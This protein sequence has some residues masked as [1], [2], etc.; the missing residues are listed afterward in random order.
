MESQRRYA[1]RKLTVGVA[2]VLIGISFAGTATSGHASAAEL[3][4]ANNTSLTTQINT[5]QSNS[6]VDA[7][8]VKAEQQSI[9]AKSTSNVTTNTNPAST[10][11]ENPN[12]KKDTRNSLPTQNQEVKTNNLNTLKTNESTT[13]APNTVINQNNTQTLNVSQLSKQADNIATL[14]ESKVAQN[15]QVKT[16]KKSDFALYWSADSADKV[17][18]DFSDRHEG[19]ISDIWSGFKG[20][21][22]ID[23][24]D[25][26][27]GNQIF[28]GSVT[29]TN[30]FYTNASQDKVTNPEF[31]II[32]EPNYVPISTKD[33][34]EFG[35]VQA[36]KPVGNRIDLNLFITQDKDIVGDV[37]INVV[38]PKFF[39]FNY[40]TPLKVYKGIS[41]DRPFVETFTLSNGKKYTQT[42]V[43]PNP[44]TAL[45]K[46]TV[47]HSSI[48]AAGGNHRG[49]LFDILPASQ[50]N[51]ST[52]LKTNSIL[53]TS[54]YKKVVQITGENVNLTL[55]KD[56]SYNGF[57]YIP[58]YSVIDADGNITTERVS[59]EQNA[60]YNKYP[61]SI[62]LADN[63]T[64]QQ[65]M[66]QLSSNQMGLS[67]QTSGG[68]LV[69]INLDSN[70]LKFSDKVISDMVDNKSVLANIQDPDNKQKIIDNTVNFYKTR[71]GNTPIQMNFYFPLDV[72]ASANSEFYFKDVTPGTTITEQKSAYIGSAS[73]N[74]DGALAKYVTYE[75]IDDDSSNII[76]GTPITL[77]GK[78]GDVVTP[79]MTVPSNYELVAGQ[80]LPGSYTLK[81]VNPTTE[82]HIK[83]K[84][85]P[86]SETHTINETIHYIY[87]DGSIA[88][89]DH[90]A[91]PV[92]VIRTGDKDL[93]T[94]NVKW[95]SW[96]TET[97][98]EIVT[99]A[100]NGYTADQAKI[101]AYTVNGDAKDIV[102]TVTY[103]A[104]NQKITINYIDDTTKA[105]VGTDSLVGKSNTDS[106]YNTKAHISNFEKIGYDLVSDDTN[107]QNIKYDSD[108]TKDQNYSIHLK[109]HISTVT[110]NKMLKASFDRTIIENLPDGKNKEIKQHY[111]I[112][113]TG[114][115][116]QVTKKYTFTPWTTAQVHEDKIDVVD[117]YTAQV[118]NSSP[119]GF[120]SISNEILAAKGEN[121]TGDNNSL[122]GKDVVETAV[123]VYTPNDQKAKITYF[124]DSTGKILE[125]QNLLGKTNTDSGY[126]TKDRID[127]YK[128]KGYELVSDNTDGQTIK[129]DA[130]DKVD[131]SYEVHFKHHISDVTDSK[132][133]KAFFDRTVTTHTP[134]GKDKVAKQHYV[135]LRTGTQ[136]QVTKEYKFT[137]WSKVQVREDKGDILDG[138][139][140][141]VKNSNIKDIA[142]VINGVPT[143]KA[144]SF[145]GDNKALN[146]K[147]IVENVEFIYTP[148]DQKASVTYID[149]TTNE[150]LLDVINLIGK[151]NTESNYSTK[152]QIEAYQKDGYDLVSDNTNGKNIVFD[153]KDKVDQHFEVHV[154]HH[155]SN[156]TDPKMLKAN[157]DRTV[158]IYTPDGKDK[159]IK[160]HYTISREGTQDQVTK[161]YTF[162]PWSTV[163]VHEDK[164]DILDGYTAQ[165]KNSNIKDIASV[166]NG[167]PTVKAESFTG[168]NKDLNGKN[169]VENVEFIYTPNDQKA[170]V[171]YID[172]TTNEVLLDVINLIGKS[173]T[174]SNY[175]TKNQIEAYQKDGYDLVSDDTNGKNIVFDAKDKIDQ[176]FEVHVKHHISN[177][178][179]DRILKAEFN[180]NIT[181]HQP[182]GKDKEIT[183]HYTITRT[184][185]QDQVTKEYK[186]SNWTMA[187]VHEDKGDTF[188][189]YT[190]QIKSSTPEGIASIV[191]G[192]PTVK[193]ETFTNEKGK[194]LPKNLTEKV[195]I[196]YSANLENAIIKYVDD[197]T[198]KTIKTAGTSG[199]YGEKIVFEPTVATEINT[200][201]KQG[202]TLVSNTFKD[203]SFQDEASQNEFIVHLK[204]G[205]SDVTR[206][207]TVKE[208]IHYVYKDGSKAHDDY[209]AQSKEFVDHGIKDNVTGDIK[210]N[211]EFE[212]TD[213]SFD[214]V[215]SP[216]I[217]GYA[218]DKTSIEG[219]TVNSDSKDLEYTV[220]YTKNPET[221]V[222]NKTDNTIPETKQ[223]VVNNTNSFSAATP[224]HVD[225]NKVYAATVSNTNNQ[226]TNTLPQ[227]G[228][229]DEN[230]LA[231]IG[232]AVTGFVTVMG[233]GLKKK[234]D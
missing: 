48:G 101:P 119:E 132:M 151:S 29:A 69:G 143:V 129:Y 46:E 95:N 85:Q 197:T 195:E 88:Q 60:P 45:S 220:V 40:N 159:V 16:V 18:K 171:T 134:D 127:S 180:R 74:A 174:E 222:P 135:I 196:S 215:K 118:K 35:Y 100:I 204:H 11:Q 110:D 139:T 37:N 142:S 124:D 191:N 193:A 25:I 183:Q 131:Q 218:A 34:G 170:S 209:V 53:S 202:Y 117:G 62:R 228:A 146:G 108:D 230:N 198:G 61:Q 82:V 157:F 179:D 164:G 210:W 94:G 203:Q 178:T 79:V 36:S 105:I 4:N 93:V 90:K 7:P 57:W 122:N 50:G 103:K 97:F 56:G 30:N 59:D 19:V 126:S 212:P 206:S 123:I 20:S 214:A 86:T 144:E 26:K 153:A 64:P 194:L 12:D 141:Q 92:T 160:Q 121:F 147:D 14:S 78:V 115:Q 120:I 49:E 81:D 2:S 130:K 207:K 226:N 72:K 98:T 66:D 137:P 28:L 213:Y 223:A 27:K 71:T 140:A 41:K 113:R 13:T 216:E 91:T 163:Q 44:V 200:L 83:H 217:K 227:T 42:I 114:T 188:T 155:I 112:S 169:V 187:Q 76:V 96:T 109:H 231:F 154:K 107:G 80:N 102:K 22:T 54:N 104:N 224:K 23:G 84:H 65:I 43:A 229:K 167:I 232:L 192:V 136:D 116:D 68:Y 8:Q 33:A 158:T 63:L 1:I 172:D 9:V 201:E 184:G 3:D 133:L 161:E 87:E 233:Y 175:S 128:E 73:G 32:I 234:E 205:T 185:T 208:T 168:D 182:N 47:E 225:K 181:E 189:G 77:R 17:N 51:E 176:H 125:I 149:D 31:G 58:L 52:L 150:V 67:K 173:N 162:T 219:Q 152:N 39:D 70:N 10:S 5:A 15:N 55:N 111:D 75:F 138:Y 89:P 145:T 177:V 199:H 190:A 99:P 156:V 6:S 166:I 106:G 165:V 186:F 221:E 21:Y 24:K 38:L 211:N 148:N